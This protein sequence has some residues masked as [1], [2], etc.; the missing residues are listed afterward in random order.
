SI[1]EK[2]KLLFLMCD[3]N[4]TG[5]VHRSDFVDLIRS[6]KTIVG[7]DITD[8]TQNN[9]INKILRQSGVKASSDYLTTADFEAIF[10]QAGKRRPVAVEFRGAKLK[11]K[12]EE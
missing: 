4:N 11:M 9:V 3:V 6:L 2:Y 7:V 12:L 5:R 1:E 10:A 8:N